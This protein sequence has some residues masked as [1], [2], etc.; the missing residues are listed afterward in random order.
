MNSRIGKFISYYKPYRRVFVYDIVTAA[1]TAVCALL[2]PLGI[3]HITGDLLGGN[4]ENAL[5]QILWTGAAMILLLLIQAAC[6]YVYDYRGHAMGAD[7]ESDMRRELFAHYQ[8][9]SFRFFDEQ[10]PG[11]LMSRL[12][13]DLLSLAEFCHHAPEDL[14][15]YLVKFIGAAAVLFLTNARLTFVVMAFLPPMITFAIIGGR[16]LNKA[17]DENYERIGDVNARAEENLSGIR[18]VQSFTGEATERSKFDRLNQN[19]LTGRKNIYR[20]ESHFYNGVETMTAMITVAVAV[21]GGV[22]ILGKTLDLVD[23][24]TFLLYV[25]YITEPIPRLAFI[26]KQYQEGITSFNRFQDMLE[27]TPD[28]RDAEGAKPL[29]PV[30][31]HIQFKDVAFRYRE[32]GENVLRNLNLDIRPGEY[33]ALVGHSGAGKTT[34]CSLIPRFYDVAEGSVSIDGH[35]V[36]SVALHSLRQSVGIVQQDVYLFGDTVIE[37]IR[38]A[39]PGATLDEVIAAAKR[40]NAHEFIS[41]LPNGYDTDIGHRGIKLSGGQKQRLSIARAFLKNPP[42]LIFDEATSSLDNESERVIQQS[43]ETLSS[44]R[45][46]LVIAHRLSTIRNA[47]RIVVLTETGIQEQGTHDELMALNG[48]YRQLYEG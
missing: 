16:R 21:F 32:N 18:T 5:N 38:Y 14:I 45:T 19:Y 48:A 13:N 22:F 6:R 44:G 41:A 37:N 47:E 36:R 28:I 11:A 31:G 40:A 2:I 43:L 4:A 20:F 8:K 35:D 9:L 39:K 7:M 25:G 27:L 34:L 26:V 46:T 42:I 1:L 29:P 12:T 30:R 23:L 10:K 3:R 17:Y 24:L 15:I 33:V